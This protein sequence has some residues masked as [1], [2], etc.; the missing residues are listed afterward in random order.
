MQIIDI[1]EL[2]PHAQEFLN[3]IKPGEELI[4]T[5]QNQTVAR[6]I[7]VNGQD[8]PS[9]GKRKRRRAGTCQGEAWMSPDFNEPLEDFAE[10]M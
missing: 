4:V 7:R 10:Y 8:E 3:Q 6:I 2:T 9:S 1:A 5:S